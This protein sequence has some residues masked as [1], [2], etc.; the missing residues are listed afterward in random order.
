[1]VA[2]SIPPLD[3]R[4]LDELAIEGVPPPDAQARVRAHLEAIIPEMRGPTGGGGG[5]AGRPL[6]SYGQPLG[7][8]VLGGISGAALT[9]AL[10][11][12]ALFPHA[13]V[14]RPAPD[15]VPTPPTL[16][17]SPSPAAPQPLAAP[18][19]AAPPPIAQRAARAEPVSGD[20]QLAAER[21]LLDVAR[22][23]LVG[24]EPERA[25]AHLGLHQAR[26]PHG[27]LSEERD[28][29]AVQA[30]VKLGRFDEARA[31]AGAFRQRTPDSLFRSTVE[32]AIESIAVTTGAP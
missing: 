22:A 16:A 24:S 27:F 3:P 25:L 7:T 30:L 29:M 8:F 4:V 14:D 21:R 5:A 10:L 2:E 19:D 11:A 18:A 32:S 23:D 1:V 13:G 26:Y 31:R 9:I 12:P 6:G 15:R 28:A 17:P 20:S